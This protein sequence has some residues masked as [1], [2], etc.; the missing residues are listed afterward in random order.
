VSKVKERDEASL[1]NWVV[2]VIIGIA[3]LLVVGFIV[4]LK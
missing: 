3:A 1:P 2:I 4:F